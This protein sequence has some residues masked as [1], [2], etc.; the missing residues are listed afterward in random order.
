MKW[1]KG[2]SDKPHNTKEQ[3]Q[4]FQSET[5]QIHLAKERV[6]KACKGSWEATN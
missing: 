5:Q 4:S 1:P 2:K 3:Y 6:K